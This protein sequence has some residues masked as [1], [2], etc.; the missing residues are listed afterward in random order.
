MS[1]HP[2]YSSKTVKHH[3]FAPRAGDDPIGQGRMQIV[4][5]KTI[6]LSSMMLCLNDV[7]SQCFGLTVVS[8]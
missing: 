8:A 5:T 6:A 1:R 2:C 3:F 7:L 4:G